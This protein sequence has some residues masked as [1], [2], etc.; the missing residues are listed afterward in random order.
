MTNMDLRRDEEKY[1]IN[2]LMH[3]GNIIFSS[4]QHVKSWKCFLEWKWKNVEKSV[5]ALKWLAK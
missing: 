5:L 3:F 4:R 2:E 1:K